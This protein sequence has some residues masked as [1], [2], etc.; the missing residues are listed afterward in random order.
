MKIQ[1]NI[2]NNKIHFNRLTVPMAAMVIFYLT[3]LKYMGAGPVWFPLIT[4]RYIGSCE[5]NWWAALCYVNNYIGIWKVSMK[6]KY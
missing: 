3:I 1:H 5:M 2:P 6:C 4:T